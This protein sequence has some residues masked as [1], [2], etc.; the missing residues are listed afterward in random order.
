M[1]REQM[2]DV[3]KP[4]R[5][6]FLAGLAGGMAEIIWVSLYASF[7]SLE[8]ET[9]AR[10]VTASLLPAF[11]AG[12]AGV[13][14]GIL[15]HMLLAVVLG[16]A[17]A[18]VLW[19]PVARPRGMVATLT[20]SVLT[21]ATAWTMNFFVVLP[22]LNPVFITLMPYPVTFASKMLFAL[23]MAVILVWPELRLA[24]ERKQPARFAR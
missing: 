22:V 13:W 10:E 14:L 5:A 24:R 7:T 9:V 16:Y 3:A 15:I 11:A 12:T 1:S 23:A 18:Y 4:W 17:F 21:L 20:V 19:K 2:S 6:V 8:A